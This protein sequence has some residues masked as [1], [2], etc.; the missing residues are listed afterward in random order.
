MKKSKKSM[1]LLVS[2]SPLSGKSTL[3]KK[4]SEHFPEDSV[5]VSSDETRKK[6]TGKYS[7]YSREEEMWKEILKTINKEIK[8][9]KLVMLDSTLRQK[10]IRDNFFDLYKKYKIYFIAFEKS[11]IK[12]LMSRNVKRVKKALTVER[13][14][15]LWK[16]YE[17]P[18]DEELSKFSKSI[19]LNVEYTEKDVLTIVDEIKNE[20]GKIK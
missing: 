13:M 11:S 7:D 17:N 14:L 15:Q 18:T 2:G 6:L 16:E 12:K 1:L 5:I 10:W 8:L 20:R 3:I 4:I 19:R 9:G